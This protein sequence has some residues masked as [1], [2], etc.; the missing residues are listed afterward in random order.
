[1]ALEF[2]PEFEQA[3][4]QQQGVR[5]DKIANT[6]L[7]NLIEGSTRKDKKAF[8]SVLSK[9][10]LLNNTLREINEN[11]E[12]KEK[13]GRFFQQQGKDK[14]ASSTA[15]RVLGAFQ[16][17]FEEAGYI[18]P[19]GNNP[20][21][22]LL[23]GV[24][25]QKSI[26]E[27]FPTDPV[28]KRPSPY[29]F[30]TYTKL[31]DVVTGLLSS[32]DK[33]TRLAGVQLGMHVLGGYRPS[34]F[35][36]LKIEN[37]DFKTGI[38]SDLLVK[39]KGG[40]TTKQGYFPQIIR[41]ILLKEVDPKGQGAVFPK[42]NETVINDALKKSNITA[43]Y[44]NE[45]TGVK[46]TAPFTLEDTR[47][48]NETHLTTLG[49]DEKDPLRLVATL[50]ANKTTINQYT[51][52]GAAGRSIEELFIKT[53]TP[54]VA[55]SGT[56][57]HAQYVSDIGVT[58]SNIVKRYKVLN[59]V[60]D[61]FPL[62]RVAEFQEK[63]PT[64]GFLGGDE[65]ITSTLSEVNEGNSKLYQ[66]NV[67]TK[68]QTEKDKADIE[69]AKTAKAGEQARIEIQEAK[70]I[71]KEENKLKA[72]QDLKNK[73]ANALDWITKN[74]GK[75]LKRGLIGAVGIETARQLIDNPLETGSAIASEFLLE[76]GLGAGPGAFASFALQ[77]SPAG[78]GA[79]VVRE[80]GRF[81][82]GEEAPT[83]Q[84]GLESESTNFLNEMQSNLQS[85][86]TPKAQP[87]DIVEQDTNIGNK[88]S[89][90][91]RTADVSPGFVT[92]PSRQDLN[93]ETERQQNFLGAT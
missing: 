55:F 52:T 68:L 4:S 53:S 19:K 72:A 21:R 17:F 73:G 15:N 26:K 23:A 82:T 43:E 84:M 64:L 38:V 80:T 5:S 65:V 54:H 11:P 85:R 91:G 93:V 92:P 60:V 46:T 7:K 83:R 33:N 77:S 28:R 20:A 50:R 81:Q 59:K 6:P 57:N 18:G 37:I 13:F 74:L 25:G 39:D 79:D 42:N 14:K 87:L 61:R 70:K 35:K 49:Y 44:T 9:G 34:D 45:K 56:S 31:K 62:D 40:S 48:L 78:E 3:L 2:T 10:D 36:N 1:M 47:K 24:I 32:K 30:E 89:T 69:F 12:I 51:A 29:P 66:D 22:V 90:F 67:T 41:D 27:L 88:M 8:I 75:P 76:K 58:P 86:G 63:Y 16:P 71:V